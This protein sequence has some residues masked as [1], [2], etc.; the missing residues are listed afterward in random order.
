MIPCKIALMSKKLQNKL[1][2]AQ[3]GHLCQKLLILIF[4]AYSLKSLTHV[5]YSIGLCDLKK[6]I[7]LNKFRNYNSVVV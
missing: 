6:K 5:L 7:K 4:F 1:F 2:F 3:I